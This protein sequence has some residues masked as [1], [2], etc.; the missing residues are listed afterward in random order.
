[1]TVSK[2]V[3]F[4]IHFKLRFKKLDEANGVFN[5][6]VLIYTTHNIIDFGRKTNGHLHK[7][8]NWSK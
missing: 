4:S 7:L 3:N 6:K 2:K 8:Q 5:G 1:M